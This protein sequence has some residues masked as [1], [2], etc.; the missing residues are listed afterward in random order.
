MT[1]PLFHGAEELISPYSSIGYW[2]DSG[3]REDQQGRLGK[4][5]TGPDDLLAQDAATSSRMKF[6]QHPE[7]PWRQDGSP[8]PSPTVD[9][10]GHLQLRI[11]LPAVTCFSVINRE[12]HRAQ[13]HALCTEA[14]PAVCPTRLGQNSCSD[15][16][17]NVYVLPIP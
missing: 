11:L 13:P 2:T 3:W 4:N 15:L 14:R 7:V 1:V 16:N 10:P 6:P 12:T 8:G 9:K 5:A 17:R